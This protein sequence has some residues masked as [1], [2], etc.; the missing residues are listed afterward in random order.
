M[1][2]PAGRASQPPISCATSSEAAQLLEA[3]CE[4]SR[5]R[6]END[7]GGWYFFSFC[8]RKLVFAAG[9]T[10]E[11]AAGTGAI[12]SRGEFW[13]KNCADSD[14]AITSSRLE[15]ENASES[16]VLEKLAG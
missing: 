13:W 14:I 15:G 7:S 10:I 5:G 4:R 16:A 3:A 12:I 8:D 1:G 6:L 2:L 11:A 9:K